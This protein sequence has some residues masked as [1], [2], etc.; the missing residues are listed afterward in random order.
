MPDERNLTL[1]PPV[2]RSQAS[3][4]SLKERSCFVRGRASGR[5]RQ[6]VLKSSSQRWWNFPASP[7]QWIWRGLHTQVVLLGMCFR[8]S[9]SQHRK[10]Q[11]YPTYKKVPQQILRVPVISTTQREPQQGREVRTTHGTCMNRPVTRQRRAEGPRRTRMKHHRKYERL[12][13]RI[14][15]SPICVTSSTTGR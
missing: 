12:L 5:W 8:S 4:F 3:P 13:E 11:L 6:T 14:E 9:P 1:G 2:S 10:W 7:A 15:L